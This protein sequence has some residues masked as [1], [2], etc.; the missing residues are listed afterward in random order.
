M[1]N[2]ISAILCRILCDFSLYSIAKYINNNF[3]LLFSVRVIFIIMFVQMCVQRRQQLANDT[4]TKCPPGMP[5]RQQNQLAQLQTL[6]RMTL[7]LLNQWAD[8]C[9]RGSVLST[10]FQLDEQ[11]H[12]CKRNGMERNAY[13]PKPIIKVQQ[14]T[15][16]YNDRVCLALEIHKWRKSRRDC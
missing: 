15:K 1:E 7:R 6:Q 4:Q 5:N 8:I 16:H 11:L 3:M 10:T 12:R 2:A 9:S 14:M 13:S